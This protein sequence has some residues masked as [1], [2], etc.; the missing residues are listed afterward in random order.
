MFA[1][2]VACPGNVFLFYNLFDPAVPAEIILY[3]G[4]TIDEDWWID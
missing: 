1:F 3:I 4:V 2:P